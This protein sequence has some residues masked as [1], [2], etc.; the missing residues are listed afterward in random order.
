MI[1]S[2]MNYCIYLLQLMPWSPIIYCL[3][4]GFGVFFFAKTSSIFSDK[5]VPIAHG[6]VGWGLGTCRKTCAGK[7]L[8]GRVCCRSDA[9][10]GGPLGQ[11][12]L[13]LGSPQLSCFLPWHLS[14]GDHPFHSMAVTWPARAGEGFS[15][16]GQ[17]LLLIWAVY[18]QWLCIVDSKEITFTHLLMKAEISTFLQKNR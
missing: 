17:C 3:L 7:W 12:A 14:A 15:Y 13:P 8:E 16:Q 11:A 6:G 4:W 18:S 2:F 1:Q 5:I 10:G 9:L